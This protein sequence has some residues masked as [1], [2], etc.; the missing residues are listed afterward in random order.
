[1]FTIIVLCT[2]K[3]QLGKQVDVAPDGMSIHEIADHV[4]CHWCQRV[5]TRSEAR[6]LHEY[7][8]PCRAWSGY[9]AYVNMIDNA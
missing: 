3:L 1:M 4:I 7:Y 6:Q 5:T 9:E 2:F 8:F